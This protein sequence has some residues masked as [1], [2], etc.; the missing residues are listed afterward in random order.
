M[1]SS[2]VLAM[3]QIWRGSG[4]GEEAGTRLE[5]VLMNSISKQPLPRS[6]SSKTGDV[7]EILQ[8]LCPQNRFTTIAV[9]PR[10]RI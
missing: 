7:K 10:D 5:A 8:T 1:A 4:A 6:Q 9:L 2:A 3:K